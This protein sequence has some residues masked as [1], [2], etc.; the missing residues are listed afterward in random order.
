MRITKI[1]TYHSCNY[2]LEENGKHV[3]IDCSCSLL[4]LKTLTKK[5][6]AI[7]LSHGHFDHFYTLKEVQE[8][9]D[10][11]VYMHKNAYEKLNNNR[12]NASKLFGELFAISLPQNIVEFVKE[13]NNT[14]GG[15]DF[16][17]YYAF[18]HTNCSILIEYRD[19]LFT[20]D[21][22]FENSYGRTDLPTGDFK[23]MQQNLQ[24]YA[25][26][27]SSHICYYGH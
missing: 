9:Y 15:L 3:L 11:K 12:L 10:C 19:L 20:G 26:L 25:P 6:D 17:I 5:L 4:Q 16:T 2:L 27:V 21:F 22:I 13:G 24:K 1:N 7:I 14:I 23:V 8:Y 18:G